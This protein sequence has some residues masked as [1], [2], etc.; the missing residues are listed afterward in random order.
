[1]ISPH[2][3][4]NYDTGFEPFGPANS[5]RKTFDT[6]IVRREMQIIA[7]DLHCTH[8]RITGSDPDRIAI[9]A[10]HAIEAGMSV[11]FSPFPCNLT[12]DELVKYFVDCALKAEEIRQISR[13]TV[14]VLGCELS[15]FNNGFL[16]GVHLLERSKAFA[17]F[18]KWQPAMDEMLKEFFIKII[19]GVRQYFNGNITYAAGEWEEIDWSLFDI[20]SVDLY[21]A[22]HNQTNYEQQLKTYMA[23]NK[24]VAITEFGCCPLHGASELGGNATFIVLSVQGNELVVN[25]GWQYREEEQVIYL[26][27]LFSIF[28]ASKVAFAFWFTFADY[29]KLHSN[30]A[31]HNLDMASYGLV[32]MLG[33]AG[34]TY[35]DMQ[36][37]PRKAFWAM[38]E[39]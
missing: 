20:I 9:A 5:S 37:E 15:I 16:P 34:K 27:E 33:H 24:P 11:W 25:E 32:Q 4:I 1:M 17:E 6:N 38:S 21:R 10:R 13:D 19:P 2:K 28:T 26:K 14:F 3:G 12:A 7:D 29:E 35:S 31:K 18:D 22:K 30:I 39:I 36:W 23:H 8:V